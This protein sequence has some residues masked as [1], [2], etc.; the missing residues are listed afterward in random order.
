MH[1]G[2][3]KTG[4]TY[5]Q[6][7]LANNRALLAQQR[8]YYHAICRSGIC[9]NHWWF[10][11]PFLED[12]HSYFPFV[13]DLRNG[14]S[15]ESLGERGDK[16]LQALNDAC[17][18][19]DYD[20]GIISAEQFL[21]L[22]KGNQGS[23]ERMH[24]Y[25]AGMNL[26]VKVICYIRDPLSHAFSELNQ[27][28]KMGIYSLED[29]KKNPDI[30]VPSYMALKSYLDVFGAD[31]VIVRPYSFLPQKPLAILSD[32]LDQLHL[33]C[34]DLL[35]A[36]HLESGIERNASLTYGALLALDC[37]NANLA[38]PP[39]S[40]ARS[41]LLKVLEQVVP[42]PAQPWWFA[43]EPVLKQAIVNAAH[44]KCSELKS[45]YE[46]DYTSIVEELA[47]GGLGA[48]NPPARESELAISVLVP[49]V[50]GL[51]DKAVSHDATV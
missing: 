3:P 48:E 42:Q 7:S 26:C 14:E 43:M 6:S 44:A 39:E 10:A 37:L 47:G 13:N 20:L 17:R 22:G 9:A 27:K 38:A 50:R 8:I 30:V 36:M 15:C 29:I 35:G 40:D 23:I 32:F 33:G 18:S 4:T 5:L 51:L 16:S 24:S 41:L 46:I 21:Y 1:V 19:L 31:S 2:F 12:P 49:L 34:G 11:I 28:V 25:L 45:L